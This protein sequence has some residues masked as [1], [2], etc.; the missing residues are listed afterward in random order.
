MPALA[1]GGKMEKSAAQWR[2]K[3]SPERYRIARL[4]GT[5]PPFSGPHDDEKRPGFYRCVCCGEVLFASNAKYAS[6]SAVAEALDHKLAM[7]RSET[8]CARCGGRL[9]PVV[10]DGPQ[11]TGQ[12]C[13]TNGGALAFEP[14]GDDRGADETIWNER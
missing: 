4:G 11:P 5:E 13:R 10:P 12:R 7:S 2:A 14:E 3:F 1:R 6:G 9:R 8:R